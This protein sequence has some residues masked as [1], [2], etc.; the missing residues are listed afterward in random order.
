MAEMEA[1]AWIAAAAAAAVFKSARTAGTHTF[2]TRPIIKVVGALRVVDREEPA[3]TPVAAAVVA[4]GRSAAVAPAAMDRKLG[5]A[6]AA[7][8]A[9]EVV[10]EAMVEAPEG[11]AAAAAARDSR[12]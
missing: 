10:A 9:A 2:M 3:V 5:P 12:A 1:A 4:A 11:S 7:E 6:V 8:W